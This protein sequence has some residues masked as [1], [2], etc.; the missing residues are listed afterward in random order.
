MRR[1]CLLILLAFVAGCTQRLPWERQSQL[2]PPGGVGILADN[3]SIAAGPDA[4]SSITQLDRRNEN[5]AIPPFGHQG[6]AAA[7]EFQD[8]YR[9]GA[10]DKVQVRVI[11]EPELT[12]E[13]TIDPSGNI[14]MPYAQSVQVA[15]KT[16]REVERE[17]TRVLKN[18]YLRNPQVAVQA[19]SLRPFYIMGEVAGSG[20]YAYQPGM[21]VQEAIAIAGGYNPRARR[22]DVMLTRRNANGTKTFRVPVTTHVYPGDIIYVRERFF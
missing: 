15:G 10:G 21:T 5:G 4:V 22:R 11:G 6:Q 16:P 18:G 13:Y 1:L 3:E 7:Y 20:G 14:S 9:L 12:G 19:T 2:A 17:L 8:G